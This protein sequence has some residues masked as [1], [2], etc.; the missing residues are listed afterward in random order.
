MLL[1]IA[2]DRRRLLPAR[3]H[4]HRIPAG[5]HLPPSGHPLRR[6]RQHRRHQRAPLRRQGPR[7]GHLPARHAQRLRR[8]LARRLARR[9][10]SLPGAPLALRPGPGRP[11]RR[12]RPHVS[13]LARL[14]GGKGVATGFG[15][16]LVAA[17]WA[18]LAA[19]GVFFLVL[20]LSRYVSLASILG[21][22]SFPIFAWFLV[23]GVRPPIFHRRRSSPSPCSSSS[24]T[25][26]TSAACSPA[27]NPASEPGNRMSRI[28]VL[29]SGAWGTAIALALS[30]RGGHQVSSGRIALRKT[31]PNRRS[32]RKHPLSARLS[33]PRLHRGYGRPRRH[34]PGGN[35]GLRRPFGVSASHHRAS[36][37]TSAR[38]PDRRLRHQGR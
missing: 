19:I 29:G 2:P 8:R 30:R 28:A 15:V 16:F 37:P 4:P 31:R 18:A 23:P 9:A 26:R 36:A 25:T 14:R 11:L 6:Q 35:G 20:S 34:R 13:P 21:A 17:P 32:P 7:R 10:G 38:R 27:R 12:P 22:A 33:V 24:S 3:I 5:A 1:G